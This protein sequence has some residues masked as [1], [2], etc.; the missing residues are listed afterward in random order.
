MIVYS[1]NNVPVR[2]TEERWF[3]IVE[4]HNDLAG[5]YDDILIAIENPDIVQ[6]GY[7]DALLAIKRIKMNRW[8]VVVY[9]EIDDDDGFVVTAYQTS[10]I[11]LGGVLWRKKT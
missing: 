9:K 11:K 3:H 4:N 8:L 5:R 1:I 2:L 10:K 6:Q 7:R